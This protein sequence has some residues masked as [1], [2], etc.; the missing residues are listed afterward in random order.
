MREAAIE[1]YL[2]SK[3]QALG[4]L[5]YK[6]VSPGTRGVPDRILISPTGRVM[7][8]EVKRED[9]IVSPSQHYQLS[10]LTGHGCVA[11]IVWSRADVDALFAGIPT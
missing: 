3:V 5:S 9:G 2:T 10:R 7:F 1:A 11:R 8:I 4:W 6:F